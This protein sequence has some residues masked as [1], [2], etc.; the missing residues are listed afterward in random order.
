MYNHFR[1]S[2]TLKKGS[3][4][5]IFQNTYWQYLKQIG[6]NL[7]LWRTSFSANL[8][9][10]AYW[11]VVLVFVV[12]LWCGCTVPCPLERAISEDYVASEFQ[13]RPQT[14]NQVGPE[15]YDWTF[16]R[17]YSEVRGAHSY[18][19]IKIPKRPWGRRQV[20]NFLLFN[21]NLSRSPSPPVRSAASDQ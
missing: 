1:H 10:G 2:E 19:D 12:V 3:T 4:L 5:A 18:L 8:L 20:S 13:T 7:H 16:F 9:L 6:P 21:C 17:F 11:S 15:S 14:Q